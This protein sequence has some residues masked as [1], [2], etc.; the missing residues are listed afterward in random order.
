MITEP[1]LSPQSVWFE[2]H[3]QKKLMKDQVLPLLVRM[4]GDRSASTRSELGHLCTV[5]LTSRL[6]QKRI[7][8]QADVVDAVAMT[9]ALGAG[10]SS[11]ADATT[12]SRGAKNVG[13]ASDSGDAVV[14]G[15]SVADE[16][17]ACQDRQEA[18]AVGLDI[19]IKDSGL[20]EADQEL[21]TL[22]ILLHGDD[23]EDVVARANHVRQ[24][25]KDEK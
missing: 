9:V 5:V 8:P 3:I 16:G 17:S 19:R 13:G 7:Q 23:T 21:L 15:S 1:I 24:L 12:G 22:L 25:S 10:A 11:G 14:N 4:V 2:K 6:Q 20:L 18:A